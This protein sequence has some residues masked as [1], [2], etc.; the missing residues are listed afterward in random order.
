MIMRFCPSVII[1]VIKSSV[2]ITLNQWKILCNMIGFS[3]IC[4]TILGNILNLGLLIDVVVYYV[5]VKI[6]ISEDFKIE[7]HYCLM[8]LCMY[9]VNWLVL[10]SFISWVVSFKFRWRYFIWSILVVFVMIV[11]CY[12]RY[13][14]IYPPCWNTTFGSKIINEA[15]I[16][17]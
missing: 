3:I 10:A 14:W 13:L 11:L 9:N 5:V 17:P 12:L 4:F 15:D 6:S 1:G 8:D 2:L 16:W 7:N